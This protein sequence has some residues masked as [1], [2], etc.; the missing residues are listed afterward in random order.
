MS[1]IIHEHIP[2]SELHLIPQA[3][4][5]VNTEQPAAFNQVIMA[6]LQRVK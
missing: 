6:F 5:L 3:A 1:R 2:G 4:H